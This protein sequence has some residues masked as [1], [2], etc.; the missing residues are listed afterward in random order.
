MLAWKGSHLAV[1]FSPDGR[2][3]ITSMQEPGL[4]GWRLSDRK[5]MRMSGYSARVRSLAFAADGRSL[6]TSGANQRKAET[7]EPVTL[8]HIRSHGCRDLLIYCGSINCSHSATMNADHLPDETPI[9]PLGAR[10]VCSKCGHVGADVRPDWS[11]HVN[12]RHV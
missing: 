5:D 11:P 7:F 1:R 10:M 8:G 3:V 12:K 6:A 2:F 4:H 9:R